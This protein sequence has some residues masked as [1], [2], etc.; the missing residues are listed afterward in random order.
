MVV[1]EEFHIQEAQ[2]MEYLVDLAAVVDIIQVL[3]LV[4]LEMVVKEILVVLDIGFRRRHILVEVAVV[5]VLLVE[6]EDR[7]MDMLVLV[8]MVFRFPQHLEIQQLPQA[9]HQI[10]IP[11]LEVVD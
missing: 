9:I 3:D 1:E 4:V 6:M 8:E 7:H 5:L 2:R 10:H 11:H